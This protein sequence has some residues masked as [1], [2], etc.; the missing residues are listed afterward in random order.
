MSDR[1]T[2]D[3]SLEGKRVVS[4]DGEE[5]GLVSGVRSSTVYVDLDPGLGDRLLARLGWDD[6]DQ[7]DYPV[8]A[9]AI[10]RVTGDAVHLSE[11]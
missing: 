10:E 9:D 11:L 3:D 8:G 2:V 6:V 5:I 1:V 7:R 4:S